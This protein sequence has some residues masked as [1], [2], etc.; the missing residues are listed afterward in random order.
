[1]LQQLNNSGINNSQNTK[2]LK[3][4]LIFTLSVAF[5]LFYVTNPSLI[6]LHLE[7]ST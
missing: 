1:M 7:F 2:F 6:A 4:V 5:L 3:L